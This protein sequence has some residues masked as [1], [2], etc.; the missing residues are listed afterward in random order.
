MTMKKK[1]LAGLA[2]GLFALAQEAQADVIASYSFDGNAN[3][4]SGNS[5]NL[6][7]S[8]ATLTTDRFNNSNSAYAFNG[9]ADMI[10][11]SFA[12]PSNATF[13]VWAT[14]NGGPNDMLFNTGDI[15]Q[16]PDLYFMG[17]KI[18]W[19]TWNGADNPFTDIPA[20]ASDGQ[21]HNYIVVANSADSSAKLYF[22]G[23][24]LGSAGYSAPQNQ[25]TLGGAGGNEGTVGYYGWHGK[26]DDVVI[27]NTAFTAEQATALYS[28][29]SNPAPVPV[30]ATILLF[31]TGLAGLAG[32]R[33]KRKK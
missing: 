28:S 17:G 29:Y 2:L 8:G 24:L 13:S 31:G 11:G 6:K 33:L 18:S 3:D 32:A 27:Y 19:N 7:V 16:G 15:S 4:I 25:F 10:S 5:N 26:I 14:W 20:S 23:N 12:L 30:P 22:D 9:N 21:F 1:L